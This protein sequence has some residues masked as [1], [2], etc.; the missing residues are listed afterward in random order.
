[1]SG[2]KFEPF[3]KV[4][5]RNYD[6]QHWYAAFYSSND[7]EAPEFPYRITGGTTVK[8]CIPYEGNE[9]LLGTTDNPTPPEPE[10]KWGD[11]VVVWND[12]CEEWQKALFLKKLNTGYLVLLSG[13]TL[14]RLYSKCL[15]ADW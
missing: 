1:M 8:Q 10:F 4:L 3:Q 13:E 5:V 15:Y 7:S 9:H 12:S 11:H 6:T 14:S 2:V